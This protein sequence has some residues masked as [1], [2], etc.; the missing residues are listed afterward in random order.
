MIFR[1]PQASGSTLPVL[2]MLQPG[3]FRFLK[4]FH[5][6]RSFIGPLYFSLVTHPFLNVMSLLKRAHNRNLIRTSRG[7]L[8][9]QG[10]YSSYVPKKI[11]IKGPKHS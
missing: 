8:S 2:G 11:L 4:S 7:N 6:Q 3:A 5:D 1:N 10:M 9:I